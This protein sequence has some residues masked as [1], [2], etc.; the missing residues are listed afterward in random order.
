MCGHGRD[1]DGR[2]RGHLNTHHG[3]LPRHE[4]GYECRLTVQER[5]IVHVAAYTMF[6]LAY[7]LL[8]IRY[9]LLRHQHPGG[10]ALYSF[11]HPHRQW[12][13]R[14]TGRM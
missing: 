8:Y 1:S 4:H 6:Q 2:E 11:Y 3:R 13:R 12:R 7:K 9:D 14:V 5:I 10:G